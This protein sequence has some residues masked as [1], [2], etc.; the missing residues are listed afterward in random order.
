MD[1]TKI[2]VDVFNKLAD[3][4]QSKFMDVSLYHDS[5]TVFC[6]AINKI[7]PNVLELACGPGNITKYLISQRPDFKIVATDL[8]P[9]MIELA[10]INNPTAECV[11]MDSKNIGSLNQNYDALMCGFLLP[12]LSK[13]EAIQLISDANTILNEDGVIYISTMEGDYSTSG[14]RKGSTGDEIYMHYHQ[15][16]YLIEALKSN[17]FEIISESRKVYPANDGSDTVDLILIASKI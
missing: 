15:A 16:D 4:Y 8:A 17:G 1:K 6:N 9:N 13:E 12:Y 14:F 3:L 5:F 2:A 11:L 10:K 7:Q